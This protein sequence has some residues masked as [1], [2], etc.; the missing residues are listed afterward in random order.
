MTEEQKDLIREVAERHTISEI[1]FRERGDI[2]KINQLGNKSGLG[3]LVKKTGSNG[4][5]WSV[6]SVLFERYVMDRTS[7]FYA[8]AIKETVSLE[9]PAHP[10][11][12]QYITNNIM[13]NNVF[14]PDNAVKALAGLKQFLSSGTPVIAPPERLLSETVQQL[15]FYQNEW[16]VLDDE[17]KDAKLDEYAESVFESEE[18]QFESLSESQMT[19][20]FLTPEILEH[21][22]ENNR[23]NLIS[24][25]QVYDL[26]QFCIDRFGLDFQHSESARGILFAK[27]Y[28]AILKDNLQRML[29]SVEEIAATELKVEGVWGPFSSFDMDKVTIGNLQ[30]I[31]S[32]R[33]VKETLVNICANEIGRQDCNFRWWSEHSSAIWRIQNTGLYGNP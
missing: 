3:L 15:P 16:A 17:E 8:A 4:T 7:D 19:R 20:F 21:L 22:S 31:L 33:P 10:P 28:E 13:V 30:Y 11:V 2:G 29:N 12:I 1:E 23:R 14:S 9:E 32:R 18:F 26:L 24:A 6:N 25:I 27:V 5:D